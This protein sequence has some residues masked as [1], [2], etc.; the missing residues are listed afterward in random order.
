MKMTEKETTEGNLMVDAA[1][2]AGGIIGAVCGYYMSD[3]IVDIVYSMPD[4]DTLGVVVREYPGMAKLVGTLFVADIGT[5][6]GALA[7]AVS[8]LTYGVSKYWKGLREDRR[9]M[10]R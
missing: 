4:V 9:I 2:I 1:G 10:G 8:S 7:G 3:N 5:K 6:F